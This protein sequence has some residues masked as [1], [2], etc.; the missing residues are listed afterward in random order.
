MDAPGHASYAGRYGLISITAEPSMASSP[1]TRSVN[2]SRPASGTAATPMWFG[3]SW[4]RVAKIPY[5]RP[6]ATTIVS[7]F[8]GAP[9]AMSITNTTMM[10]L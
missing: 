1:R 4:L 3:R 5:L 10:W 9:A 7:G 6:L 2:P 8:S